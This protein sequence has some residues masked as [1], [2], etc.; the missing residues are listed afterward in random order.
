M[1]RAFEQN[2]GLELGSVL[3]VEIA[4]L[5]YPDIPYEYRGGPQCNY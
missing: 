3:S 4:E 2:H 1:T 5:C